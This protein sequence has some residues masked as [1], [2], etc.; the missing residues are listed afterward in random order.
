MSGNDRAERMSQ[1]CWSL[2]KLGNLIHYM[3]EVFYGMFGIWHGR[4]LP[5]TGQIRYPYLH[6]CKSINYQFQPMM[7]AAEAMNGQDLSGS[8]ASTVAK[9]RDLKWSTANRIDDVNAESLGDS[10]CIAR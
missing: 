6:S 2:Q 9:Y 1:W 7:V 4:R 8:W 10:L 5:K 3:A